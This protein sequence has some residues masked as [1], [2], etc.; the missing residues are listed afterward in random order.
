MHIAVE[1]ALYSAL[2][3]KLFIATLLLVRRAYVEM[4][5]FVAFAWTLAAVAIFLRAIQALASSSDYFFVYWAAE[6]LLFCAMAFAVVDLVREVCLPGQMI[7]WRVMQIYVN[8]VIASVIGI[9]IVAHSGAP[10]R[11]PI[12]NAL[13]ALEK[14][15]AWAAAATIGLLMI[16][17]GVFTIH[18]RRHASLTAAGIVCIVVPAMLLAQ[19]AIYFPGIQKQMF[20]IF[21]SAFDVLAC[22][23]W[24]AAY[25]RPIVVTPSLQPEEDEERLLALL[26]VAQSYHE[27]LEDVA[28]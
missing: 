13:M 7:S 3:A 24:A 23:I 19:A 2:T 22:G 11:F 26:S 4:P 5:R 16:Y 9:Y 28:K 25:W 20:A 18:W 21:S 27:N 8:A 6:G 12:L 14:S 10:T 1:I 15:A 17:T